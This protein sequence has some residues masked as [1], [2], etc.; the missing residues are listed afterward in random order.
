VL[1]GGAIGQTIIAL[2]RGRSMAVTADIDVGAHAS[3]KVECS[4][5]LAGGVRNTD[6]VSVLV[7]LGGVA[8]ITGATSLAVDDNLGVEADR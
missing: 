2:S 5:L 8:T 4:V 1:N 3:L 6:V 7:N